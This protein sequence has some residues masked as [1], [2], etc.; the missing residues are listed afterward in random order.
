MNNNSSLPVAR[1]F[2]EKVGTTD[3]ATGSGEQEGHPWKVD[4]KFVHHVF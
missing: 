1:P 4:S 3:F 2:L